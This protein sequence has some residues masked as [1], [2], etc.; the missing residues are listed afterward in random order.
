MIPVTG[1][2]QRPKAFQH[3]EAHQ[4]RDLRTVGVVRARLGRVLGQELEHVGRLDFAGAQVGQAPGN[5]AAARLLVA[6]GVPQFVA[7]G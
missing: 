1:L 7:V 3:R 4:I 6:L 5:L 2:A